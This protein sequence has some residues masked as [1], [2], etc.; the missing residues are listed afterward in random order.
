M[1]A[2]RLALDLV[3]ILLMF[4]GF[5]W[6]AEHFNTWLDRR[7]EAAIDRLVLKEPG[8]CSRATTKDAP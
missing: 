5:A 4:M 7:R 3:E 8:V 1:N 6:M 2:W